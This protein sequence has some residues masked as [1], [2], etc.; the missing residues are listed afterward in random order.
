MSN[1]RHASSASL[2][3]AVILT[4]AVAAPAASGQPDPEPIVRHGGDP[5]AGGKIGLA[6]GLDAGRPQAAAA[7]RC[8]F[9]TGGLDR[10][11]IAGL[12]GFDG[13]QAG[14]DPTYSAILPVGNPAPVRPLAM[15][16]LGPDDPG[17]SHLKFTGTGDASCP[18]WLRYGKSADFLNCSAGLEWTDRGSVY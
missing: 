9:R 12:G 14:I 18:R 8:R 10:D 11:W 15:P 4:L 13:S 5:V 2:I 6:P 17:L 1:T 16:R 7:H 3:L